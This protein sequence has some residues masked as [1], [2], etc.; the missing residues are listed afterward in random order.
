MISMLFDDDQ[1]IG[2]T[3]VT[4]RRF[5]RGE[6]GCEHAWSEAPFDVTLAFTST[7]E[8]DLKPGNCQELGRIQVI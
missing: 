2:L 8:Q 1:E 4:T 3:N 7:R 5:S 6:A